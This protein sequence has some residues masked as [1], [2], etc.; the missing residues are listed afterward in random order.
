MSQEKKPRTSSRDL[1][2]SM[3]E[4]FSVGEFAL[5]HGRTRAESSQYLW[6]FSKSQMVCA[7]GGKSGIFINLMKSPQAMADGALWERAVLK[8]MPSALIGGDEVLAD[9][10]LSTQITRQRCILISNTDSMYEIAGAQVQR[11]PVPWLKK[12]IRLGALDNA[13]PG[14]RL[15]R[16]R[17]GA[18]LADLALHATPSP[19]PDDIDLHGVDPNEVALFRQLA[20]GSALARELDARIREI[21]GE[22]PSKSTKA[23]KST[24]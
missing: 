2:L 21:I 13:A 17:P 8:A 16:L 3:P 23:K 19:D 6:R 15:A 7:L 10:G 18:A 11:R 4:V 24:T 5:V 1:L 20:K 14:E 9:S 12:L 22:S